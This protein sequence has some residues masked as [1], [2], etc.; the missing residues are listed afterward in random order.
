M[1]WPRRRGGLATTTL[2]DQ[3][4]ELLW[5]GDTV[6]HLRRDTTKKQEARLTP[7]NSYVVKI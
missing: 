6:G 5:L 4:A 2:L 7:I 1:V 3:S